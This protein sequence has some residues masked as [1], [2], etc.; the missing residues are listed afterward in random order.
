MYPGPH[1][2]R[3]HMKPLS[4][5]T[6][7]PRADHGYRI[8]Y[9]VLPHGGATHEQATGPLRYMEKPA[10]QGAELPHSVFTRRRRELFEFPET[11]SG[12]TAF[13][14]IRFENAKGGKGP[15]GPVFSA[16]IP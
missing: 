8:Y 16:V 14:A 12:M 13:F 6:L 11:D 3:L 7:D 5:T 9:G 10:V 1:L 4:G 2:L 15:W